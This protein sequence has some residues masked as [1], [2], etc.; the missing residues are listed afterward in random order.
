MRSTK[1]ILFIAS[2]ILIGYG[3]KMEVADEGTM[4]SASGTPG[5]ILI[6]VDSAKFNR[7]VGLSIK[8]NMSKVYKG[9]PQPEAMFE[10]TDVHPTAFKKIF[11]QVNSGNFVGK[12]FGPYPELMR[13]LKDGVDKRVDFQKSEGNTFVGS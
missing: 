10:L 12:L 6:V 13:W 7:K 9:L 4:P 8:K 1:F 11:P 5:S 3:C 2:L